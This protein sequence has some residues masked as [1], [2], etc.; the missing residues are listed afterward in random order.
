MKIIKI[1]TISC[2]LFSCSNPL[3]KSILKPLEVEELKKVTENDTTFEKLY[4]EIQ[5]FRESILENELKQVKWVDLTYQSLLDYKDFNRDTS[6][7]GPVSRNN[8]KLW[9]QENDTTGFSNKVDSISNY[10]KN[11]FNEKNLSSYVKVELVKLE[12]EYYSSGGFRH[13]N[14]G[15]RLTPL[16]GKLD[17]VIFSYDLKPK[18]TEDKNSITSILGL[19]DRHRCLSSTPLYSSRTSYWQCDYSD[20]DIL[21]NKSLSSLIRDYNLNIIVEEIRKNGVNYDKDDIDIP[22]SIEQLWEEEQKTESVM[23]EYYRKNIYKEYIDS[24]F[25]EY[26]EYSYDKTKKI[27]KEK[28]PLEFEFKEIITT[29]NDD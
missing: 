19:Y 27:Q 10:W 4:T 16:Q 29:R 12:K 26:W 2:L 28:F 22:F 24:D 21:E 23:Y 3:D 9:E 17:Q 5:T 15:F 7:W 25:I 20:E 18:I 11:Y 13:A 14:L 6:F 8:F 1:L